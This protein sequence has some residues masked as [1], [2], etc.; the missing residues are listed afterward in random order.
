MVTAL[1]IILSIFGT[2]SQSV[3][4]KAFAIRQDAPFVFSVVSVVSTALYFSVSAGKN[5]VLAWDYVPYSV[6]FGICY[7]LSFLCF[8]YAI[9][10][11]SLALTSLAL[12]Y[13]LVIPTLF[14]IIFL[15]EDIT[16]FSVI[17]ILLLLVSLYLIN[18]E[19]GEKKITLKWIIFTLITA[20][21]NGGCMVFIKVQQTNQNFMYRNEFM[22]TG[23]LIVI[24]SSF[25][26]AIIKSPEKFKLCI[27]P[28]ILL[29]VACGLAN[30][31]GNYSSLK[32]S[33]LPVS[34]VSPICS[35]GSILGTAVISLLIYKERFNSKQILGM[36]LGTLSVI[37]LSLKDVRIEDYILEWFGI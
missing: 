23:L 5:F 37:A 3:F 8:M 11:G 24:V 27:K 14:G 32:L 28:V 13:S 22:V 20:L 16:A 26:F 21:G 31:L 36:V 18:Y 29:P 17:G 15:G 30:A 6:G 10:E 19:K 25:I 33:P 7:T 35:A 12:S 4:K 34:F 9:K 1:L 2:C